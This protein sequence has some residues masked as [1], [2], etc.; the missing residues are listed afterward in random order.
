MG[1][2]PV[3]S[4]NKQSKG[5]SRYISNLIEMIME[6]VQRSR[7]QNIGHDS[8]N[9]FSACFNFVMRLVD[10]IMPFSSGIEKWAKGQSP[11]SNANQKN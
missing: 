6:T 8:L 11:P 1:L 9:D 7:T 5:T 4:T 3:R 2:G 10:T